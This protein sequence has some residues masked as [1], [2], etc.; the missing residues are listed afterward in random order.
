MNKVRHDQVGT[1]T[2]AAVTALALW[3]ATASPAAAQDLNQIA[4]TLLNQLNST[5]LQGVAAVA[6]IGIAIS[7]MLG[8]VRPMTA[9]IVCCGIGIAAGA[10]SIAGRFFGA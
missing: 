5:F 1:P 7:W 3:L 9:L 4:T 8:V 10:S 2:A 6:I